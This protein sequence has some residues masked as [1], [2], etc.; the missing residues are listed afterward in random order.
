MAQIQEGIDSLTFAFENVSDGVITFL[1]KLLIALIIFIVGWIAGVVLGR[2]VAQA[3][4]ALKVDRA[5]ETM[6][7][8]EVVEK[9]G[10]RLNTGAFLGKLVEWF[11]IIIFLISSF[12]VLGLNAVT[13]FLEDTV[14][15]FLPKVFV[16]AL[17]IVIA[18]LI[19]DVAQRIVVGSAKATGMGSPN[20]AGGVVKWAIWVFAILAALIQLGIAVELLLTLFTGF[21]AMVAIAGGLAFGLG[22]KESAAAYLERLRRDI[23]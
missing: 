21:V 14:L 9:A 2:V 23:S 17:I 16:A 19:S 5:M 12:D 22:G 13:D 3:V 1:P 6:K 15:L 18:A 20:F 11:I 10:F 4:S 8:G 7:V